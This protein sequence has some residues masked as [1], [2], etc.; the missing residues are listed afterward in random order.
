MSNRAAAWLRRKRWAEALADCN[1]VLRGGCAR[2][3]VLTVAHALIAHPPGRRRS[4]AITLKAL[5][6]RGKAHEGLGDADAALADF[7][8]VVEL[9]PNNAAALEE[10]R[11]PAC[12]AR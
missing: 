1:A 12:A 3:A 11:M 6:R 4:S 8:R 10:A 2:L 5:F 7:K 9:E